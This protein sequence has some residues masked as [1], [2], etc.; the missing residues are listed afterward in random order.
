MRRHVRYEDRLAGLLRLAIDRDYDP[1]D[2]GWSLSELKGA[3]RIAQRIGADKA[4][5]SS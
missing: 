3:L 5:P 1:L 4:R 2:M